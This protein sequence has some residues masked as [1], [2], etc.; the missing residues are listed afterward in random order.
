MNMVKKEVLFCLSLIIIGSLDLITTIVGVVFFGANETNP[1]IAGL[2][3]SNLLMFSFVKLFAIIVTGLVFYKAEV[4]AKI[5]S[6]LSPF[7]KKFLHSG[8]AIC[9]FALSFAV[10][11]NFSA[12]IRVA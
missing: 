8:F 3:Q 7:A 4:K 1:L 12:I 9:F 5:T 11:N 10:L 6:Q 2:A